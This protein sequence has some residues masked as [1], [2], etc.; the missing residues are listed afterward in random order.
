MKFSSPAKLN[1]YLRVGG[2]DRAGFHPLR[3]WMVRLTLSD[4]ITFAFADAWSLACDDP[5]IPTDET[6]L[7]LRAVRSLDRLTRLR[8][9]AIRLGKRIPAGGGVGGGSSN[10]ATTLSALN[11]L[12]GLRLDVGTLQSLGSSLGSDVAFFL[13]P[14]S[15]IATGRGEQLAACRVP[16][17]RYALLAFP[18]FGVSTPL[19]YQTLDR[20][21]PVAPADGLGPFPAD[22]WATFNAGELMNMLR[23]DL[24]PAA[25]AIEPRLATLRLE[26]E[27]KLG[28]TVR[29]TGS[30][31]TLFTLFDSAMERDRAVAASGVIAGVRWQA[32][33]IE[34]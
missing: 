21:R 8:P 27:Q 11:Q 32:T 2:L 9:M 5:S 1:L 25:F 17:A 23:N 12:Q 28:R 33:D 10:A 31:S 30:G 4:E 14:P 15:A 18:S 3:S 24:E 22:Q 19:A 34:D 20:L 7:I 26:A 29:M 6:N 16:S 13:G